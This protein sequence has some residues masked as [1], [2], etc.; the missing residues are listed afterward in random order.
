MFKLPSL[1]NLLKESGATLKRFPLVIIAAVAATFI[2]MYLIHTAYSDRKEVEYLWKVIMC[3]YLGLNLFLAAELFSESKELIA[4]RLLLQLFALGL[5]ICYYFILP[6]FKDFGVREIARYILYALG[7]HLL[8]SFAPFINTGNINGFWQYN[9]TLFLRFLTSAL[10]CGV[11]FIGL[12]LALLAIDNLFKVD[13]NDDLYADLWWFLAGVFNT[14]FF[15]AGIP[16]QFPALNTTIH[17][18]KGLKIF[19]QF[20]LLPLVTIYLLILYAY[21]AKITIAMELPKGWVSYLVIYFSIAGI[22]SLL[23]IWP[24]RESEGNGWI[25]IFSRWFYTALYPL[26]IL[27][28]LAIYERVSQYGI[29]ENRYFVL[30]IAAWLVGIATYF[31]I[32]KTKNIKLI[33]ISLCFTAF[34]SSF[35]PWGVFSI[36]EKSQVGR[37]KKILLEEKIL[38]NG[39]IKKAEP[40]LKGEPAEKITAIID[41]L[42]NVHG[43]YS[44]QPWFTQNLDSLYKMKD[45]TSYYRNPHKE[46]I[47]DLMG[48][49]ESY[50]N[51]RYNES[52]FYISPKS[53]QT[54]FDINGFDYYSDYEKDYSTD[55]EWVVFGKDSILIKM[56]GK[57]LTL[58]Q[59]NTEIKNI[60]LGSY[61]NSLK[62]YSNSGSSNN[63]YVPNNK[64]ILSIETDS[65]HIKFHFT[66]I[67]GSFDDDKKIDV[68]SLD[69]GIVIKHK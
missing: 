9:K 3:C 33:P 50:A 49:H 14:W 52:Y 60:D 32:S 63:Y 12:A 19:T 46:T 55:N 48:V 29:T 31:L 54:A 30:L 35:G 2:A 38:I 27:L 1:T 15:L 37:L 51:D 66:R 20:V 10:Y 28:A 53:S 16:K 65:L 13:L 36:S 11:L 41:Y 62:Q 69:A 23:L 21:G 4:K 58:L 68:N 57:K 39:K 6:D 44:I 64:L 45:T 22:L 56:N 59:N 42:D 61:V 47:L 40:E 5:I 17:Y 24:I 18:P 25:K 67:N 7:L 34:L 43:F 26:I 8:V